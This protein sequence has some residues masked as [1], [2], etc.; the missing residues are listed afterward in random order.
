M[1]HLMCMTVLGTISQTV[2]K[3]GCI[4]KPKEEEEEEVQEKK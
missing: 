3:Y 1:S 4:I 2:V